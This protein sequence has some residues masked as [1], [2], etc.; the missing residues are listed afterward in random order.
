MHIFICDDDRIFAN[1]F[2]ELVKEEL[3]KHQIDTDIHT[4]LSAS[5][6]TDA[7][8]KKQ[9]C[10]I[11]FLDIDMP[12]TNGIDL[13][14]SLK[15]YEIKPY[16][17]FVSTVESLVYQTFKVNPFWLSANV[18]ANQSCRR[19]LLLCLQICAFICRKLLL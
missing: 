19:L 2:A 4:F 13:A 1:K 15:A 7:F 16:L 12:E 10:D 11:L 17:I 5:A 3:H 14:V 8:Q 9:P 6:L 18:S